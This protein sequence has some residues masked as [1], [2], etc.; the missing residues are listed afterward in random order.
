M[1]QRLAK[2]KDKK[3]E[4]RKKTGIRKEYTEEGSRQ[5]EKRKDDISKKGRI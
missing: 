1:E 5:E 4:Y 2:N 3:K